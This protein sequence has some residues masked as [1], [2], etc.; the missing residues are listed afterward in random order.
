MGEHLSAIRDI[1]SQGERFD[2]MRA[3]A[4][5]KLKVWEEEVSRMFPAGASV[6]DIGCGKGREAFCLHDKGFRV[7]GIDISETAVEA[8]KQIAAQHGLPIDFRVSNGRD[9]LFPDASF[10]VVII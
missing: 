6:L 2:E 1:F 10:D 9:L 5:R 4:D 7:T 8:A 3:Y